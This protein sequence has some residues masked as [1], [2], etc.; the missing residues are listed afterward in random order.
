M[1]KGTVGILGRV[2]SSFEGSLKEESIHFELE[3][4][5]K[6]GCL[7]ISVTGCFNKP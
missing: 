5:W 6:Q 1:S 4:V 3:A 7:K 2:C